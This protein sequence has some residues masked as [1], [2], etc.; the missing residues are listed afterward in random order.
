MAL[1]LRSGMKQLY[2]SKDLIFQ[3]AKLSFLG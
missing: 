1:V 3:S 2:V